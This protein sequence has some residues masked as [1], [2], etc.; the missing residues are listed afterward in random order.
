MNPKN[1]ITAERGVLLYKSSFG[2]TRRRKKS[3][4]ASF[5][6]NNRSREEER[7]QK[8]LLFYYALVV[9]LGFDVT[10]PDSRERELDSKNTI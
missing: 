8:S 6:R 5:F 7:R 3:D 2:C 9:V 10:I 4:D 1:P